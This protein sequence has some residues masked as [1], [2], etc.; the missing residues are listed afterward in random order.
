MSEDGGIE[1]FP[2]LRPRRR[3]ISGKGHHHG[4]ALDGDGKTLL[5]RR[6]AN[7]PDLLKLIGDVLALADGRQVTWAVDMTGGE[8]ALLL[9]LLVLLFSHGQE[10]LYLP[11][12]LVNQ[13]SDGY[14]RRGQDRRPRRLCDRRPGRMRRDL[15]PI[16]PGGE[17]AIELRLLTGRRTDLVEDRTRS[18]K[19]L[20]GTLLGMFPDLE[21]ALD[22]TSAGPLKLLTVYQIPAAIGRAGATRL[23]KWLANRKV[24]NARSLAETAVGSWA[25]LRTPRTPRTYSRSNGSRPSAPSA[26]GSTSR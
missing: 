10:V 17:A 21:R 25:A 18:V 20:R 2:E 7:E 22:V 12:L 9:V 14:P 15:R 23:T 4:L 24:R 6:V 26:S 5:S 1:E 8:P 13:A 11:G 19:R 16:R 3:S